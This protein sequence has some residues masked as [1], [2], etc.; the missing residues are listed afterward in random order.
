MKTETIVRLADYTPY[1]FKMVAV[2]L[3]F[4]LHPNATIVTSKL[5]LKREAPGVGGG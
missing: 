2:A 5:T 3:H 4:A 1:P